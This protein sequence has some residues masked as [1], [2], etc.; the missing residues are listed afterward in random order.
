LIAVSKSDEPLLCFIHVPK[1]AGTAVR[2]I[3]KSNYPGELNARP[4]TNVFKG[5]GGISPKGLEPLRQKP[6]ALELDRVRALHG[7]YPLG[8]R[9]YLERALPHRRVRCFTFLRDPVERSISHYFQ[10]LEVAPMRDP[11]HL[12]AGLMPLPRDTT[13][14]GAVE[15]GYLHDNVQTRMLSGDAEP[16][17]EVTEETLERAKSNVETLALVGISERMDESLVLAKQRLGFRNIMYD[18]WRRV[19]ASRPRGSDVPEQLRSAARRYND[20]DLELYRFARERFGQAPERERLEFHVEL[21]ALRAAVAGDGTEVNQ[22][23]PPSI[24]A[25]GQREWRLLVELRAELLRLE[26]AR[27]ARNARLASSPERPGQVAAGGE[28]A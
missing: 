2:S 1:T 23:V 11:D 19:N 3:L 13:F 5:G 9:E 6:H 14:D 18:S 21:A 10:V 16:F 15:A 26:A 28:H 7:H 25:G 20:Y 17:G 24:F 4:L 22:P 27:A 12:R 8:I